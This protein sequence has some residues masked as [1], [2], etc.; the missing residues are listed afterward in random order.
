MVSQA[1][2]LVA[3]PVRKERQ[4][5]TVWVTARQAFGVALEALSSHKLRSFLTLLGVVIATTTLIVVMSIVNGMN[6]YI[7]EHIANLGTNTFVLHQF[8]WAQGFD[9]FLKAR[10]R[11]QPIRI[12]DYDYLRENLQGYQNISAITQLQPSPRARYKTSLIEEINLMGITPSH[13]DIGREKVAYG[14]YLNDS[15]YQHNARVCFIGQDL[16]E[17]LFPMVDP[18]DKEVLLGGLPFRV[19]GVAERVGSTFGQSQDNFAFVP[20]TTFRAVWMGRPELLVFIKSPDGRH[21]VELEDE[22]RA[23]M[24]ARRHVPYSEEDTFGINAS[25]TLMSAWQ[26][27][28]GT[29]FA[30]TIGVVAVFMVVGGIVIMNIMLASVTE[31]THEIGIRKSVGAR[32]RDILWQ[33]VI[34]AGVMA[35][36]GGVAGV[37]LAAGIARLVNVFFTAAV[38]VSAVIVGVTL[39]AAVGLF[40]GIYP[41]S[42][43]ARLDP[44]EALRTEN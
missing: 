31:R 42:K 2:V 28:T 6:V 5:I 22:V 32:R 38:P 34:E 11:N 12:E 39:S 13:A 17:K 44:I 15:D 30:V 23:L 3:E 35:S 25:D 20:L 8:K 36:I 4:G 37:L 7:A 21:M 10:R 27:L 1:Q 19:I 41:A 18:L 16:V 29:I 14:R 40:F 24:R 33:F 43:A 9:S 26:N